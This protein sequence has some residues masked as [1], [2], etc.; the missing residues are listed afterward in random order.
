MVDVSFVI[1]ILRVDLHDPAADVPRLGVP[2]H[3][4]AD[5]DSSVIVN[6]PDVML[7]RAEMSLCPAALIVLPVRS[8]ATQRCGPVPANQPRTSKP[9]RISGGPL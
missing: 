4:I 8:S 5:F 3:V 6:L 1:H 7:G 9:E 2:G